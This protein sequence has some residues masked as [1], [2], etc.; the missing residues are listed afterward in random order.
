MRYDLD[1]EK[2]IEFKETYNKYKFL[3]NLFLE[4]REGDSKALKDFKKKKLKGNGIQS[5][6]DN[7]NNVITDSAEILKVFG[8]QSTISLQPTTRGES[9]PHTTKICGATAF[10]SK[11]ESTKTIKTNTTQR[12]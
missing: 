3:A 2:T 7:L 5:L 9:Q 10:L 6:H 11:T 8:D 1:R 4:A 12:R